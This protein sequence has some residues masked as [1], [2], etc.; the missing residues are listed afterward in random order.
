MPNKRPLALII[1]AFAV[2]AAL[3]P[4][5]AAKRSPATPPLAP[6]AAPASYGTITGQRYDKELGV[7]KTRLANGLIILTKEVHAAPVAYFSVFYKVGSRNEVTGQTGLSHILEHMMFKGTKTLPPGAIARLFQRN[8]A[9]I[10]AATDIDETFYHELIASDR[11]ELAVRIEADR[12]ENSAFDPIQ[13]QHEMSVVRSELE[14][15]SND[16]G[17]QLHDF[18]F[19]P[20]IMQAHSYHWP[21][22]GWRADVENAAKHR[23]V[24]Y[25]YYKEHYAPNNATVVAVGDFD[26]AKLVHLCQQYFGVYPPSKIEQHYI[27]PEPPQSGERRATLK[28]P[29]TVGQVLIGW[30][31]SPLGSDDHYA[32]DVLSMILSSGR[33][34]RLYQGLVEKE[35][36][37]GVD[38]GNYDTHDPYVFTV[39]ATA[40][41]GV[42][43]DKVEGAL[44]AVVDKLKTDLVTPE[45]LERAKNEIE[46]G[47]TF[48]NDSVSD[49]AQQFGFYQTVYGDYRYV[50]TYVRRIKSVT[51]E[52]IRDVA[53]KYFGVDQR[54]VA[55][56]DPQP[57][58]Q[59]AEPPPP[60]PTG[61][62]F[63]AV[64]SKPSPEQAS[65]LAALDAKF[66]SGKKT[67]AKRRSLP[68]RTVLP[69]GVVLIVQENHANKTVA[70]TGLIRA[71][72]VFDPKTRPGLSEMTA[73]MLARGA[74]GK[75][76][77]DIARRLETAG[78]SL[79]IA[80]DTEA[81]R[82]G[83][84]SLTKDFDLLVSTL[85]DELRRPDFPSDQFERL[86]GQTLSGIEDAR[87]DAGG[88]SGAG[89]A[90]DIALSQALY[91]EEHPFWQPSFD[92]QAASVKAMTLGEV[93]SFHDTYYRP[94]TLVLVVVGDVT[95]DGA[96]SLIKQSFGD[97]AKPAAAA[98]AVVIPAVQLPASAP[99]PRYVTIPDTA[100]TSILLGTVGQ[101]TRND[102][103]FYAATV[104]NYI[105]G[106]SVFGSRLG[107]LIRDQNGLAYSVY[108]SI[109]ASHGAGPVE[110]FIG[111]N[112][113]NAYRAV[114]LARQAIAQFKEHGATQQEVNE[115][116]DYLTGTFPLTLETN[117]GLAGVIL[118]EEDY[119]F[120]LDY[121]NRRASLYRAVTVAKVNELA[122]KLI[123]P[124]RAA[125]IYAGAPPVK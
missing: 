58:P 65:T 92:A 28:R 12:M 26:S 97:W 99:A 69:N 59:G 74:G 24:I 118:A 85:A 6:A 16:P 47:F 29:G 54:T 63:G 1:A 77:L 84:K 23:D 30:H 35:I 125:L 68:V 33:T 76:A 40:R 112:P 115:A 106:G 50:S 36:A 100:Q 93:E 96:L 101:L 86:R 121:V 17:R 7:T 110:I 72:E 21:T 5:H 22:I 88:P 42:S 80:S 78:A 67:A 71:G 10:N 123:H 79:S 39:S 57:L 20:L 51:P 122:K 91:P 83:G 114:S 27:T 81:T 31:G 13:L 45:E 105:L 70:L 41:A 44:E 66:G 109:Q 15:D 98:P 9:E 87:Q 107:D 111:T 38:A 90:A 89:E 124:E 46:A 103:D 108:S 61:E 2:V 11:L 95:P 60:A 113:H 4:A 25:R 53:R 119:G 56:F 64:T 37:E 48:N 43:N 117:D 104:M 55:T 94:D 14:G 120:G 52:Q 19:I 73:L 116:I 102:P 32:M 75:S 62:H 49:Q 34:S 18:T 82:L 8:G 3:P